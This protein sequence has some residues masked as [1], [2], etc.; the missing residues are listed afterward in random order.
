MKG[1]ANTMTADESWFCLSSES[2][3]IFATLPFN[4]D[5]IIFADLRLVF[6]NWM[7]RLSWVVEHGGAYFQE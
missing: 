3:S 2:D 6:L 1:F 4:F 7:E 5:Q